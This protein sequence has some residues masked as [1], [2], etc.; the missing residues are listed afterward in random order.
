MMPHAVTPARRTAAGASALVAYA[1]PLPL[2]YVALG[3][4]NGALLGEAIDLRFA[5]ASAL[6]LGGIAAVVLTRR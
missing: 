2:A 5:L 3:A 1:L 6:V 4:A